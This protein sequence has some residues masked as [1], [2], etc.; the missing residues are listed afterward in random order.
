MD[1]LEAAIKK[2]EQ[3]VATQKS[4]GPWDFTP[5]QVAANKKVFAMVTDIIPFD[6]IHKHSD[7]DLI[8]RFLIAK[9]WKV[10]DAVKGLK[11]YIKYRQ[12]NKLNEILWEHFPEELEKLYSFQGIDLQGRPIAYNRPDPAFVGEMM[13]KYPREYIIRY[14]LKAIEQGRRICLSLGVDRIASV[15]DMAKLG[16]AIV[17]NMSAMGLLKE[18]S[19]IIQAN[20]PEN[21]KT[22]TV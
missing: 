5:E 17:K 9:R 2:Y 19:G 12:D 14:N 6:D 13:T 18:I 11:D 16:L 4:S 7:C 1:K 8:Y 3:D 10:E 21:L 22:M 15:V 20:F